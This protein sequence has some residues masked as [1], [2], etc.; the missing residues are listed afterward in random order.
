MTDFRGVLRS[1]RESLF[2]FFCAGAK[3]EGFVTT[4]FIAGLGFFAKGF[5]VLNEVFLTG[6]LWAIT[7]GFVPDFFKAVLGFSNIAR[8]R[9]TGFFFAGFLRLFF[10]VFL[11]A[12]AERLLERRVVAARENMVFAPF[13]YNQKSVAAVIGWQHNKRLLMQTVIAGASALNE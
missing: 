1:G 7:V 12:I 4:F 9:E 6:F 11:G 13:H 2:F 10:C 3:T 5:P 8:E